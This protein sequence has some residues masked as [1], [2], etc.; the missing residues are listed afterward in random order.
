[1]EY[2]DNNDMTT[3]TPTTQP[4]YWLTSD[5]LNGL[6]QLGETTGVSNALTV[7][8]AEGETEYLEALN[9]ANVTPSP[10][11]DSGQLEIGQVYTWDGQ[12]VMV[13]QSHERTIYPPDQTPALFLFYGD[14]VNWIVGEQVFVGTRRTYND[15]TYECLQAHVTQVDWTPPNVPALWVVVNTGGGILDWVSG[16]QGIQIGDLRRYNNVVYRCIQNPGINIW[17]PPTVPALWVVND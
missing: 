17:P 14:G 9:N 10:L 16:E 7:V 13:R 15:I 2:G 8:H 6:T 3:I 4:A 1:M 5:A 11:P 12:M